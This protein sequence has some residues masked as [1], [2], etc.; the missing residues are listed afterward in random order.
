MEKNIEGLSSLQENGMQEASSGKQ[1]LFLLLA[2]RCGSCGGM[3][4][5]VARVTATSS[6]QSEVEKTG[7]ESNSAGLLSCSKLLTSQ[8]AA[9]TGQH[10]ADIA[11]HP[12]RFFEYCLEAGCMWQGQDLD[13]QDVEPYSHGQTECQRQPEVLQWVKHLCGAPSGKSK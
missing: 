12:P 9:S 5:P 7:E 13:F 3:P 6:S 11:Y 2:G 4:V 10:P 1:G 8:A